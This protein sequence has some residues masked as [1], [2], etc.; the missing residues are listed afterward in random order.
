MDHN[1][2]QFCRSS[3][4]CGHCNN[5]CTCKAWHKP[6]TASNIAQLNIFLR[7][8][9]AT[10]TKSGP[11]AP[12][13]LWCVGP[14]VDNHSR[15]SPFNKDCLPILPPRPPKPKNTYFHCSGV[16]PLAITPMK[17]RRAEQKDPAGLA[18]KKAQAMQQHFDCQ[19]KLANTAKICLHWD[20][21]GDFVCFA[22]QCHG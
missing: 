7:P 3:H 11:T 16:T 15:T 2:V 17:C 22:L 5:N 9:V 21:E 18:E 10:P 6:L 1:R 8:Y 20:N 4:L 12:S 14:G 13:N 19:G